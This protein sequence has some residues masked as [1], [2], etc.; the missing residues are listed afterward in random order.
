MTTATSTETPF[1]AGVRPRSA[2]AA[3][4][5]SASPR[6]MKL[7]R[8]TF[9]SVHNVWFEHRLVY[10]SMPPGNRSSIVLLRTT[11]LYPEME[12]AI[13][14]DSSGG[15]ADQSSPTAARLPR[16]DKARD[17]RAACDVVTTRRGV[18]L[19]DV[20]QSRHPLCIP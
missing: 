6:L 4:N 15:Q 17:A 13:E 10:A 8:V 9:P 3:M 1:S 5:I 7:I 19:R 11:T 12:T 2:S 20:R 18:G 16:S 14:R